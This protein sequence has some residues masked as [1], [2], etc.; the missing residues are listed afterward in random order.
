MIKWLLLVV[1]MSPQH[2]FVSVEQVH[3]LADR[4]A[5]EVAGQAV[6]AAI[7]NAASVSTVCLEVK[8]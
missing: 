8:E 6:V 7:R 3:N 1:I 2:G 5:C 4:R